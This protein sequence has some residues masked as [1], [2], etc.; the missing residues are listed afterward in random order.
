MEKEIKK[1]IGKDLLARKEM[2]YEEI[3]EL[4]EKIRQAIRQT[5]IELG[6]LL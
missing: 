1:E 4:N 6:E 5:D 2:T 3:G